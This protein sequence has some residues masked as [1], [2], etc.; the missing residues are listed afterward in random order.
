M[1]L[2]LL[3]PLM[4]RV[5]ATS[6]SSAPHP[7]HALLEPLLLT[8]RSTA[9]KYHVELPKILTDGGGAGEI[10]ETIMWFALEHEKAVDEEWMRS[11]ASTQA[12]ALWENDKWRARYL[13]RMERREYVVSRFG[14]TQQLIIHRVQVQILLYFLK[15]SL[16]GPRPAPDTSSPAKRRR[17]NRK[18]P[19]IEAPSPEAC[20]ESFMDKLSMWQLVESLDPAAMGGNNVSADERDWIQTFAEDIVEPK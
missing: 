18:V 17:P 9:N 16:P 2:K 1:P 12:G 11:S 6:S 14:S 7:L 20:V 15:L 3:V 4:L 8:T 5:I 19:E 10:E 13:E